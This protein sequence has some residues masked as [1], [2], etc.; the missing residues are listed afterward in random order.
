MHNLFI[1]HDVLK[2]EY[3][4]IKYVWKFLF[5]LIIFQIIGWICFSLI[6][7]RY[8]KCRIISDKYM[9]VSIFIL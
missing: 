4:Y 7:T 9:N 1:K 5:Y 3:Q 2:L 6:S 8:L